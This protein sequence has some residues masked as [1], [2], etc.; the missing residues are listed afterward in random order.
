M[1]GA[2][3]SLILAEQ[4]IASRLHATNWATFGWLCLSTLALAVGADILRSFLQL[5]SAVAVSPGIWAALIVGATSIQLSQLP[6]GY[7]QQARSRLAFADCLFRLADLT[8]KPASTF[9]A[10]LIAWPLILCGFSITIRRS[11]AITA[12]MQSFA[13][14]CVVL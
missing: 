9:A 13:D 14:R 7:G 1:I 10:F 11:A 3:T 2:W 5:L 12:V 6:P 8:Y 4:A